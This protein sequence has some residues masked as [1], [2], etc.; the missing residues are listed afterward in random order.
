MAGHPR[1]VIFRAS[2]IEKRNIAR[3]FSKK[4]K[5]W[6]EQLHMAGP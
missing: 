3:M 6:P 5:D 4:E 1:L 2:N